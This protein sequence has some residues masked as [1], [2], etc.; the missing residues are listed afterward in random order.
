ML[1]LRPV[2]VIALATA[3]CTDPPA[4]LTGSGQDAAAPDASLNC[5]PIQP[6]C[7][8]GSGCYWAGPGRF[9]CAAALGLPRYHVCRES[10]D[11]SPG[12]GC[13]LDDIVDFYC[14][15]YCDY[16]RYGGER[17]PERCG[18][19]EVCA[20]PLDGGIGIC[21]GLCDPLDSDCPDGQGCYHRTGA[22]ICLP[23]TDGSAPG[24]ACSRNNDCLPG[25]GCTGD[26]LCA[27]YCNY[28]NH[29]DQ[30]DPRCAGGEVCTAIEPGE[31]LGF[32]Q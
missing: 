19:N 10:A 17:D 26:D 14:V 12:D 8:E 25:A 28:Q 23:V 22:D 13:H 7:A 2:V 6:T 32:C 21:L 1:L 31:P 4:D 15:G 9:E 20:G 27:V 16:G 3:G 5:S 29:P 18:E 11:C 24:E 30:P